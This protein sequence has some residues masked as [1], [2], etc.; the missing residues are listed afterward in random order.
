[1]NKMSDEM[2]L[3][4]ALCDALGFDVVVTT[5]RKERKETKEA[6]MQYNKGFGYSTERGLVTDGI[7]NM[8]DIDEDGMYTSYLINPEIS[9]EVVP[10]ID[11]REAK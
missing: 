3:I 1:V 6:A 8:L 9:Y 2:K 7:N 5:D 10:K 11:V 4:K